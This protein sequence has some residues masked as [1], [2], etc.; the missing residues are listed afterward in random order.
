MKKNSVFKQII[1][2]IIN[3]TRYSALKRKFIYIFNNLISFLNHLGTDNVSGYASEATLFTIISFFPFIMLLLVFLNFTPLSPDIIFNL[4]GNSLPSEITN[5]INTIIE[6]IF[7]PSMTVISFSAL[8]ALWSA[9]RGFLSIHK[10]FNVVYK[11]GETR[12]Y[13][14]VRFISVL[15]TLVF[16][17]MLILTLILLVFGNNIS[18]WLIS[19]LPAFMDITLLIMGIRATVL[20]FL[21]FIYFL[22]MYMFLPNRKGKTICELPGAIISSL[23]W[24]GFSYIYSYYIDN[25]S[26]Y[27]YMYGSLTAIVLL[28]LW[29]YSCMYILFV[30]A[31]INVI[32][33]HKVAKY[34]SDSNTDK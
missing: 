19:Q 24:V 12:N 27:S 29:M 11:T 7:N 16:A 28:M 31:E 13:F 22:I 33:G 32:F 25:M 34:F 6:E 1:L 5:L 10:G 21:L 23:G 15:Y 3:E 8:G 17:T 14:V 26:N 9:S 4:I 2:K 18:K 30:G 20:S